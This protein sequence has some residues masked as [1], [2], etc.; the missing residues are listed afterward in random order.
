MTPQTVFLLKLF[1]V[2]A[3]F[4]VPLWELIFKKDKG[5]TK[6]GVAA[7]IIA[8]LI[9]FVEIANYHI[10]ETIIIKNKKITDSTKRA[11]DSIHQLERN[12]DRDSIIRSFQ[13]ALK[14]QELEFNPA[15]GKVTDRGDIPPNLRLYPQKPISIVDTLETLYTLELIFQSADAG[16]TN[17]QSKIHIIDEN[18]DGSL[19]YGGNTSALPASQKLTPTSGFKYR[20]HAPKGPRFLYIYFV[21]TYTDLNNVDTYT[22]DVVYKF[23]YLTQKAGILMDET[24]KPIVDFV[25]KNDQSKKLTIRNT[26]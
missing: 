17:H 26:D 23:S 24:K 5:I 2:V 16:S 21:G 1:I 3:C 9:I 10:S 13:N 4:L 22:V 6:F 25:N 14:E 20:I 19:F 11:N 15:T 12:S 18:P 8:L 7:I